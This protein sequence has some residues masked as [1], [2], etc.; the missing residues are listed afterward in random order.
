MLPSLLVYLVPKST[1]DFNTSDLLD[2]GLGDKDLLILYSVL[3]QLLSGKQYDLVIA[4]DMILEV[5]IARSTM[6]YQLYQ[7]TC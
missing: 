4:P 3:K 7:Y 6:D 2:E 1:L 5:G